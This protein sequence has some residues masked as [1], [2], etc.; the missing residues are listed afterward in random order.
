MACQSE[1]IK[2]I[3]LKVWTQASPN[4][5]VPAEVL[6]ESINAAKKDLGNVHELEWD[7]WTKSKP[8]KIFA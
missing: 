7:M 8:T 6:Q 4:F 5:V 3:K 2:R 1:T